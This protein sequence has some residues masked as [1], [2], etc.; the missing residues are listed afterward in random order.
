MI[1]AVIAKDEALLRKLI[2]SQLLETKEKLVASL[3]SFDSER[4]RHR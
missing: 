2:I 3:R 4:R 1:E